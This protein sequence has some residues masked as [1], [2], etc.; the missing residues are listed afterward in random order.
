MAKR[1]RKRTIISINSKKMFFGGGKGKRQYT[2]KKAYSN[3][4]TAIN[5]AKQIRNKSNKNASVAYFKTINKT[6]YYGVYIRK[7]K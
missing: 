3:R 4:G 5:K 1:K 2:A 7:K 6:D